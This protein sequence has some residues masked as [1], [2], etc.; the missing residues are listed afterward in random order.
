[1]R[2]KFT[3]KFY[4]MSIRSNIK[5]NSMLLKPVNENLS[6]KTEITH[7]MGTTFS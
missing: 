4:N 3:F 7:T 5:I 1:M 6:C 2:N